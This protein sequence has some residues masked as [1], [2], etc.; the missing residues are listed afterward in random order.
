MKKIMYLALSILTIGL[1]LESCNAGDNN[2]SNTKIK[3]GYLKMV[4]SLTHFVALE[5]GY[6][7]DEGLE[8]EA[9]PIKT[10]DLIAQDLV[11]GH[12]DIAIELSIVPL[13]KQ[14]ESSPKST[15]IFSISSITSENGFDGILVEDEAPFKK[16]QDLAGKRIGV[17]PGST[18]K[19]SLK[20]VFK[21][22]YPT[23]HMPEFIVIDPP[24]HIQTLANG[25][26]DAIFA[27][28]PNLT[29]GMVKNNF[30]KIS[31]SIYALQYT[32]NPIGVGA[33]NSQWLSENPKNAKA[34]FK[35]IDK[36][37]KFIQENPSKAREILSKATKLDSTVANKINIMPMSYSTNID[38]N[39]LK[40]Y[41]D[42]LKKIGEINYI[43][44]TKDI[45]IEQ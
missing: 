43:P 21:Q 5:N 11:A 3:I 39:N 20:E 27:Y 8:I 42:I 17:F 9:N 45:C 30:R 33:V 4:S 26:V 23:S 41:I 25:E 44:N 2:E 36:A 29:I 35:A 6:Y 22:F 13:L 28:E 1:L 24:L 10:S 40:G 38:Q 7:K 19:N 37:V 15:K 18:A 34:F 32:P 31:T 16:L 14:N 12:I